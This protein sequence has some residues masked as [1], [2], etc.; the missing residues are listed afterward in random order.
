[1]NY[2]QHI[3][4][5]CLTTMF[6]AFSC[7]GSVAVATWFAFERLVFMRYQGQKWLVDALQDMHIRL[8]FRRLLAVPRE[9]TH[10]FSRAICLQEDA[11]TIV[12]EEPDD[13]E[14]CKSSHLSVPM[15]NFPA[16]SSDPEH[17]QDPVLVGV[18]GSRRTRPGQRRMTVLGRTDSE[19]S[20]VVPQSVRLPKEKKKLQRLKKRSLSPHRTGVR[21]L[22]FSPDGTLL[23]RFE[24]I[25]E[26]GS[27]TLT[28]V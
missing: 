18:H 8:H 2:V 7:L 22:Q 20:M 9:L 11:I 26:C 19:T 15:S 3:V 23:A 21:L 1:M 16:H 24:K 28:N 25:H 13:P 14:A 17:L 12:I 10:L 6:S 4:T 27:P 5:S